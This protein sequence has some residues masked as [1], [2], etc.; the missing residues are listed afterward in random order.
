MRLEDYTADNI[1]LAMNL[2]GFIEQS[3]AQAER[4][5]M[6]L[7]LTPSFH[8]ELCLTLSRTPETALMSVTAL[9]EQLWAHNSDVYLPCEREDVTLPAS[10]FDEASSLFTIAHDSFDSERRYLSIDGMGSESCL[11]S[12]TGTQRMCAHVSS[13]ALCDQFV[14]RLVELAWNA[15]SRP[16]VRNALAQAAGYLGIKYP[17][18]EVPPGKSNARIAV[19]GTPEEISDYLAMLKRAKKDVH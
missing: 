1:C 6:R 19:L 13:H 10:A 12:R 4:P 7:I 3:W 11:V 17:L 14:A 9:V 5:T 18:Q 16:Q 2:P 8:P 15:C